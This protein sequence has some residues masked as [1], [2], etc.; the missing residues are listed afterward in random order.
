MNIS[1]HDLGYL[2]GS[3]DG[4][5]IA[6]ANW[7]NQNVLVYPFSNSTGTIDLSNLNTITVPLILSIPTHARTTYGVEFS[8]NSDILYYSALGLPNVGD[9]FSRRICF[10]V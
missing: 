1:V 9:S 8:P 7:S 6:I 3:R 4:K 2:K 5:R 10:P